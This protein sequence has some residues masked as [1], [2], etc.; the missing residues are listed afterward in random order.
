M[1][2]LRP[3]AAGSHAGSQDEGFALW[4]FVCPITN[5]LFVDPVV[6]TD[7]CTYSKQVLANLAAQCV[8]ACS[9]VC[10]KIGRAHV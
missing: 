8:V 10:C 4:K 5:A 6:A 2:T 9:K 1:G 7:G 3:E